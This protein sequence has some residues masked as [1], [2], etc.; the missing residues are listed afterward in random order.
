MPGTIWFQGHWGFQYYME[1]LG[2]KPL[3]KRESM[4]NTGDIIIVPSNNSYITPVPDDRVTLWKTYQ[5]DT[6]CCLTT[7][8]G[9]TGAAFY[10]DG[11]GHL[12]YV[13]GK[14]P[15]EVYYAFIVN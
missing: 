2:M 15:K 8:N 1:S 3:D 12:P 6:N 10:S 9:Y 13:F 5:L 4:P 7:M 14:A 11:W